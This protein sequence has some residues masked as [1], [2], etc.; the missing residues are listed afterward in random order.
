MPTFDWRKSMSTYQINNMEETISMDSNNKEV[1]S[2]DETLM[3]Q[4]VDMKVEIIL[5]KSA[6]YLLSTENKHTV[7]FS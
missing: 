2:L 4:L 1:I 6:Q 3:Q 7:N 5:N